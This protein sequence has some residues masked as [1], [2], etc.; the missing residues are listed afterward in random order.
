MKI[1]VAA[2]ALTVMCAFLAAQGELPPQTPGQVG[3]EFGFGTFQQRCMGCHGNPSVE[4]APPPSA[5]RL[6]TPEAI[7]DALTIGVMKIQ[8]DSLTDEMRRRVA[9]S[10]AGRPLGTAD[11]GDARRMP[12]QCA[13]KLPASDP[14]AGPSWNGWAVDAA[15]T[16]FQ[17]RKA[18]G[19]TAGQVPRLKLKWAF[20]VPNG[21]SAFGQPTIASGRV[22]T[23]T[24]TGYVYALDGKT[25]CV[26]WSYKAKAGIRNA[27]TLGPF[28]ARR[29]ARHAV[30]FGD[31]KANVYAID[32][33]T[34]EEMWTTHV[35]DHYT[36]RV[37]ATP[38]LHN[39]RLY[40]PISSWEEF[41][42]KT[43]EY[44]CCTARGSVVAL[45]AATGSIAW[46]TYVI[47]EPKP[48][49]KN[50]KGV[51]LWAPAGG[52]V[53]N[54]PTIDAERNALYFGTGDATTAPAAATSDAVMALELATGKALWVF[55]TVENDSFLV[56]CDPP[57]RTDNCPVVQGPDLDI[58]DSPILKKL[59]NGKRL[60][61]VATKTGIVYALD[62]DKRGAVV[63]K[64]TTIDGSG[65]ARGGVFWGGA[66]D[67]RRVYFGVT[68]GG[69]AA[70]N[71]DSGTGA[72]FTPLGTGP[73]AS[74]AAAATAIPGVV[75]VGGAD[76]KLHALSSADGKPLW[77]FDTRRTFTTVNNVPAKGGAIGAP[78]P[79]VA[80]GMLLVGS[81]YAVISGASAGNVLLAFA[82]E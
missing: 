36:S 26:Y 61:I 41:S 29:A 32:A 45:D 60:L 69:M 19:L 71:L 56:G 24:D 37:T 66:A 58:P 79:V 8:G 42:A 47:D 73:G 67:D 40:V 53:W 65:F 82:V 30:Y 74:N 50:S 16:R 52:S 75:F 46:K 5:L 4:K 80:G 68:G 81:G 35:D 28:G 59:S 23:G 78:G 62:P 6:M 72:W 39:G 57:D 25:G 33:A 55:Q 77:E 18:A 51:Q 54:S 31:L 63:W 1:L 11:S 76:G 44:P 7:Y 15:N 10:V 48:V 2:L 49:R 22:Y 17:P 70:L 64:S 21:V 13:S 9:E 12:N 34:G 20:G 38:T 3:T 14:L 43:L 27:M